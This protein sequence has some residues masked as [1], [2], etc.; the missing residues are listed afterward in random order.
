MIAIMALGMRGIFVTDFGA[1]PGSKEDATVAVA[2]AIAAAKPGDTV[3]FPKGEYHFYRDQGHQRELYLSNSDV[4]NPRRISVLIENK[5][6]IRLEG[7]GSRLVFHDRVM[8]FAVLNS[9]KVTMNGFTV[10]WDRALMSQGTVR[11]FDS[12]G[13]TLEI[14]PKRYPYVLENGQ[15]S[16]TDATWKRR[17]WG[18]MEF[19]PTTRGVAAGTGDSG[20]IDGNLSNAPVTEI[21]PGLLR[22]AIASKRGPKVGNVL[23]IRHGSRDHGGAFI[24]R[25]KD[26]V[27]TNIAF[28]HTSG[29]GVL[30]QYTENLTLKNVDVAP[31]PQS[32]QLFAGHDD[33]FHLSNCKGKIVVDGCHFDGLMDDPINVHGTCIQTTERK[34]DTIVRAKFMHGQSLGLAFADPGDEVSIIDRG[35]MSSRGTRLV[36]SIRRISE[37]EVEIEFTTPLPSDFKVEDALENLTWTPSLTVRNS[38][39]GKVR[40]R[41]I[42]ISTPKKVVIENNVFRSSGA[43][44][45]V[46]G[47]SNGWYESGAVKDVTIRRNQFIDCNSSSYQFCD[48]VISIHPEVPQPSKV[49]F[50]RNIRI[51]ENVFTTFDPAVLW[52]ISVDGLTFQNNKI[53]ASSTFKSYLGRKEGL[54][55]INCENVKVS[56][57]ML[58]PLFKGRTA[59][60]QGGNPETISIQGFER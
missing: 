16:F 4:E 51:T 38:L 59:L 29:L 6:N 17:P 39:F 26:V 34:S 37:E 48:A 1:K 57:N 58:D 56:G 12:T 41:G 54:T 15:L 3:E 11:A 47:D 10:D 20:F 2:K 55:L 32:D 49:P 24:E 60:V 7:H 44:I 8:P 40:A 52:A 46:A 50:H 23:I 53:I 14:D 27:M 25:S 21:R 31:S 22:F 36:K 13:L 5:K 33:A 28:R 45:F 43:A 30:A 9:Q 18:W 35:P 42:L 19:D